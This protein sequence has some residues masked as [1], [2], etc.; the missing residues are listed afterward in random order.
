MVNKWREK[1]GIDAVE[2]EQQSTNTDNIY[3]P[4]AANVT[5]VVSGSQEVKMIEKWSSC[6][7]KIKCY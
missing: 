2:G 4:G 6:C 5:G 3:Q 7:L 1:L